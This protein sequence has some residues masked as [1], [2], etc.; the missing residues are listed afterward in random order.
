MVVAQGGPPPRLRRLLMLAMRRALASK[1]MLPRDR[2]LCTIWQTHVVPHLRRGAQSASVRQCIVPAAR[3]SSS[4]RH[5]RSA[6]AAH[7]GGDTMK[8][9]SWLGWKL[10]PFMRPAHRGRKCAQSAAGRHG[11]AR[12]R[13]AAA[14]R[15]GALAQL[16]QAH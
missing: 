5:M 3:S 8:T 13:R 9:S 15:T 10:T 1:S 2:R 16:R 6:S 14:G 4:S 7:L 12:W 11:G